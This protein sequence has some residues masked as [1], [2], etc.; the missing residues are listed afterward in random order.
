MHFILTYI[1]LGSWMYIFVLRQFS[2]LGTT[3]WKISWIHYNLNKNYKKEKELVKISIFSKCPEISTVYSD[4][5]GFVGGR[6]GGSRMGQKLHR[7]FTCVFMYVLEPSRAD[8]DITHEPAGADQLWIT[9]WEQFCYAMEGSAS[10]YNP[11]FPAWRKTF[12]I[13]CRWKHQCN[14]EDIYLNIGT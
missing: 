2:I 3:V 6:G 4:T 9:V 10:L 7:S 14:M 12:I 8:I 11:L 13:F 1:W 5:L